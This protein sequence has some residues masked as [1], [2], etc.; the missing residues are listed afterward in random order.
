MRKTCSFCVK[1]YGSSINIVG[2]ALDY[3]HLFR[4]N[5]YPRI[6]EDK[7]KTRDSARFQKSLKRSIASI[8]ICFCALELFSR[9]RARWRSQDKT[10]IFV[11]CRIFCLILAYTIYNKHHG[12]VHLTLYL[13]VSF[14]FLNTNSYVSSYMF[15]FFIK[16]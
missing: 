1:L 7:S 9:K 13:H 14:Y 8:C 16:A 4:V 5:P 15:G 10:Y 3:A 12:I 11:H 2:A 6:L